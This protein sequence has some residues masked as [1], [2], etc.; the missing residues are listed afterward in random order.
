LGEFSDFFGQAYGLI[1]NCVGQAF[2][3]DGSLR[4]NDAVLGKMATQCVD[5]LSALAS[6][7]NATNRIVGREAA[8]TIASASA[9][10]FFCRFTN[11][12]T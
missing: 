6:D 3:V 10:S 8:S 9:T 11:G 1:R 2:D 4:R 12:F 7:S 5:R